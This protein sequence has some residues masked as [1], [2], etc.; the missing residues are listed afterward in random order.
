MKTE[1]DSLRRIDIFLEYDREDWQS[2][3]AQARYNISHI[4]LSLTKQWELLQ[5]NDF[6][7]GITD[8]D[9]VIITKIGTQ[10]LLGNSVTD[11]Y[12]A[13][14]WVLLAENFNI[15]EKT[16]GRNDGI[17]VIDLRSMHKNDTHWNNSV[18]SAKN[19]LSKSPPQKF[20]DMWSILGTEDFR[21]RMRQNDSNATITV[22]VAMRL[23]K[24]QGIPDVYS[25]DDWGLLMELISISQK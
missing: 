1:S 15:I 21:T 8:T 6:M 4:P 25:T 22:S 9:L 7:E 24:G 18:E 17:E 3:V 13:N 16:K 14:N 5:D 10:I 23:A 11:L 2:A 19:I 20:I 12:M